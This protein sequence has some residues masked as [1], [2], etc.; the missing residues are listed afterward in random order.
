MAH[1]VT[2]AT[3]IKSVETPV[4]SVGLRAEPREGAAD[5]VEVHLQ[6][7]PRERLRAEANRG[8]R[9]GDHQPRHERFEPG[10][11]AR[12]AL[13]G[14]RRAPHFSSFS[15]PHRAFFARPDPGALFFVHERARESGAES[16]TWPPRRF[17][18]ARHRRT[19]GVH[20]RR[21]QCSADPRGQGVADDTRIRESLPTIKLA[22]E[23]GAR[24]VLASHLGRPK[25]KP[26]KK[27]SLEPVGG[28]P[29]RAA[30][31]GRHARPTNRSATARARSSTTCATARWRCSR[32]CASRR[33]KRRTTRVSRA[34]WPATPTST[35]TTPSAPRTART[36]RRSASTKFVGD[37]GAGLADGARGEVPRQAARRRR[38]PLR[39]DHRRRQ[40]VRQDRRARQPARARRRSS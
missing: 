22:I 9:V 35:S 10:L 16:R 8:A 31:R 21:L 38:A 1:A 5:P 36:P 32:T 40:G 6:G 14:R 39:R 7:A 28:P 18:G 25:G 29:G 11:A 13:S 15:R 2:Q 37:K 3:P 23:K 33:S 26:D 30:R 19:A 4:V 12:A 34:R 20:P 24:V 27:F 17:L